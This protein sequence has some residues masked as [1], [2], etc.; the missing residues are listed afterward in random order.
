MSLHEIDND[1]ISSTATLENEF[2]LTKSDSL[3][4]IKFISAKNY[5]EI[6]K[7][8]PNYKSSKRFKKIMRG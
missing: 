3:K 1:S 2:G 8:I 5:S 7:I 4:V 6:E